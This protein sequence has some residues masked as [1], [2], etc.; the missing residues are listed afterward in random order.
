[1]H[2]ISVFEILHTTFYFFLSTT[3]SHKYT[4]LSYT[5]P[6]GIN[7][8][9]TIAYSYIVHRFMRA[10]HQWILSIQRVAMLKGLYDII[11]GPE[12]QNIQSLKIYGSGKFYGLDRK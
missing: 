1:M 11:F 6:Y 5:I 2:Y 12:K 3:L 10:L 9:I 7:H 4:S 8:T